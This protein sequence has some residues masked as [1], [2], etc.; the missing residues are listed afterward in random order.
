MR[1]CKVVASIIR[2]LKNKL[3]GWNGKWGKAL[4]KSNKYKENSINKNKENINKNKKKPMKNKENKEK[5]NKNNE[6][7]IK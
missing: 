1:I 6:K 5:I 7:S 2:N 4:R 3:K